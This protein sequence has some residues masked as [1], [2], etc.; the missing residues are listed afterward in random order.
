MDNR[1]LQIFQCVASQLSFT[2][3]AKALHM[4]QPAVSIAIKKLESE[5]NSQLF[6]RA[7]KKI[8]LTP[9]GQVLLEHANR[10]LDQFQQARLAMA[11]L[12]GLTVGEVKLCT[13]AML[14]S[15]FLPHKL[16]QFRNRYPGIKLQLLGEGTS[17]AVE[18]LEQGEVDLGIVNM[19][20]VP[21]SLQAVPLMREEIVI[22]VKED[23]EF[24]QQAHIPFADF[25]QR[26]LVIYSQGYYLREQLEKLAKQQHS[27]LHVGIETNLL[28]PLFN[29]VRE[30][31]GISVCLK[32]VLYD[33]PGLVGIP[34]EE[35]FFL[36]LGLAYHKN[37]YLPK[38][39]RALFDF[40]HQD[41]K[42]T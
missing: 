3:A 38:A 14:G 11:E 39:G 27:A 22:C 26:D 21:N 42:Q 35:P 6:D 10:I 17:R 30:N 23:D 7:E 24:A 2:Q 25:A 5:L 18:L 28:R 20:T 32:Q 8:S 31:C 13:S 12:S 15:Y 19:D 29:F 9:E 40:L 16:S 1:Q 4:A 36:N 33:E 37:R 34:F 41:A